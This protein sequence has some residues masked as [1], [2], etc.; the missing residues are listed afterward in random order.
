MLSF[1]RLH[2]WIAI[3]P[4]MMSNRKQL[5]ITGAVNQ[6]HNRKLTVHPII[7]KISGT[8]RPPQI[9]YSN[10]MIVKI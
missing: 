2:L 3:S 8:S 1:L 7:L 4:T 6:R 9:T 10:S 5:E